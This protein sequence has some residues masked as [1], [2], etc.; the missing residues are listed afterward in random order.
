MSAHCQ[1]P[2][3]YVF[4]DGSGRACGVGACVR[5]VPT[6]S[7]PRETSGPR[8]DRIPPTRPPAS[9]ASRAPR[10][11]NAAAVEQRAGLARRR[12]RRDAARSGSLRG[13]EPG[14]L[15]G[16]GAGRHR[17]RRRG[18]FLLSIWHFHSSILPAGCPPRPPVARSRRDMIES[19]RAAARARAS[20][21]PQSPAPSVSRLK[22]D[23]SATTRTLARGRVRR[24]RLGCCTLA[25][26]QRALAQPCAADA[27]RQE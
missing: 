19:A 10:P 8:I 16:R 26:E 4:T 18:P 24:D 15:F 14:R 23:S 17:A 22:T 3:L 12:R 7:D 6:L 5:L 9:V 13:L 11:R 25:R 27:V 21:S 20:P 2:C 1:A